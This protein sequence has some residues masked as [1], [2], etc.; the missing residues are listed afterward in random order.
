MTF[1]T[2]AR[3]LRSQV[4]R[5]LLVGGLVTAGFIPAEGH[6]GHAPAKSKEAK[7]NMENASRDDAGGEVADRSWLTAADLWLLAR[8]EGGPAGGNQD[9]AGQGAEAASATDPARAMAR[10]FAPFVE[11]KEVQ[12]RQDDRWLY[13]ESNGLPSH[14][15]MIG[16]KAWQQ[17][18]PLPQNYT[19]ANAWQI[20]LHPVPAKNPRSARNDFLRGAI[21]VAINGIPIFNP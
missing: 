19:G 7:P 3:R 9:A 20:P 6:P 5:L 21:A 14:P 12:V 2:S 8:L 18:V 11:R 16:I 15:L 17:Q 4:A 10:A 1:A 13:V